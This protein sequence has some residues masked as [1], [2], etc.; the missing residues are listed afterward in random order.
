[1]LVNQEIFDAFKIGTTP[2]FAHGHEDVD[3]SLNY[4]IVSAERFDVNGANPVSII[5]KV[6]QLGKAFIF[7]TIWNSGETPAKGVYRV[8]TIIQTPL[9]NEKIELNSMITIN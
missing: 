1:M 7:T 3:A 2:S 9:E 4:T 6:S 5:G 8:R